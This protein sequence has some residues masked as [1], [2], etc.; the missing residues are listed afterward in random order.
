M[1]T[2]MLF[3]VILLGFN[4]LV[5]AHREHGAHVHGSGNLGIAFDDNKGKIDFKI[6]SE[7]LFGFEHA[8]RTEKDKKAM[9]EAFAKLEKNISEM[10][11]FEDSLKCQI[12]KDKIEM[13]PEGNSKHSSTIAQYSVACDRSPVGSRIVFNFQKFFPHI[14]D[15]D[16]QVLAGSLQKSLEAKQ[17]GVV[18]E[19]K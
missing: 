12:N 8:A 2:F 6:P 9:N 19:L 14:H 5:Q 13:V 3:L 7:S 18:L 17:N 1:K 4:G 10:I 15:L 11:V 16:V